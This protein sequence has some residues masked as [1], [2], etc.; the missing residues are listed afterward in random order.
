LPFDR[1][2]REEFFDEVRALLLSDAAVSRGWF[3]PH[4]VQT[5]LD[6]PE[7]GRRNST[8]QIWALWTLEL[9]ARIFLDSEEQWLVDAPDAW[10]QVAA[11]AARCY[12]ARS[13]VAVGRAV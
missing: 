11:D 6:E 12:G 1:W 2:M 9:W 13:L 4:K 8:R 10:R 5:L 7:R 3:K